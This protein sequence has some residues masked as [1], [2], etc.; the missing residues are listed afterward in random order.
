MLHIERVPASGLS[1]EGRLGSLSE[2]AI[3]ARHNRATLEWML[4]RAESL[5]AKG[6]ELVRAQ[7]ARVA[8]LQHKGANAE[9]S[10]AL[11]AL[12]RDSQHLQTSHVAHLRQELGLTE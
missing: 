9:H 8:A 10:K 2:V 4:P 11:L 3:M 1:V 7:E 12:M 5:A 6:A